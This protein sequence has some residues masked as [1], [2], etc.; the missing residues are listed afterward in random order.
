[1]IT[2]PVAFSIFGLEIMWYGIF[3]TTGIFLGILVARS[4][5]NEKRGLTKDNFL[6][7]MLIMIPVAVVTTRLYYVLF[8]DL[9]YYLE[10]PLQ[11]LNF[12]QGGLAIHGGILG[13]ILVVFIYSILKKVPFFYLADV[14]SPGLAL[15][16]AIGRWGNYANQE[17]H[18]GPTDLP[19]GIM[20]EGVKVHPTFLYEFIITFSLFLF[21]YL[22]LSKKKKFDGQMF[23]IYLII[24]SIGRFLIEG[25]RTDSLYLGTFRIAQ[26]MSIAGIIVGLIIYWSQSKRKIKKK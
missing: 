18:G 3:I 5:V 13:G 20:V 12:R 2:N 10:N 4:L 15:G 1:M 21:L 9:D 14:I 7:L 17:A 24:Y 11:I 22:Y 26:L 23:S 19:W 8:Y 6:D 16:Q 25:L